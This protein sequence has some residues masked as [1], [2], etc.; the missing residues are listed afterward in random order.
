MVGVRKKVTKVEKHHDKST[1]EQTKA[2]Q[3]FLKL[4][5]K[6]KAIDR[7]RNK[8]FLLDLLKN[9]VL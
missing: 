9:L 4:K 1:T 2:I 7:L 3:L 6:I 8:L 5:L